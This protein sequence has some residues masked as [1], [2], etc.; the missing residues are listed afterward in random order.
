MGKRHLFISV[1]ILLSLT[2]C[3][4]SRERQLPRIY[5]SDSKVFFSCKSPPA[6]VSTPVRARVS[7]PDYKTVYHLR[8]TRDAKYSVLSSETVYQDGRVTNGKAKEFS[9]IPEDSWIYDLYGYLYGK[10]KDKLLTL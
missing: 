9:P 5:G 6:L 4:Y 7:N 2:G 1:F 8:I 3:S 10:N